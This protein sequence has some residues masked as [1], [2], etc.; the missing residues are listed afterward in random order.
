VHTSILSFLDAVK[1]K[2]L[3]LLRYELTVK[4]CLK[5]N[6]FLECKFIDVHGEHSAYAFKTVNTPIYYATSM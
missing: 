6:L 5:I 2:L 4:L 3:E 1:S